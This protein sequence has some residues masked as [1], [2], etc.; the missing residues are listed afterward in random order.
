MLAFVKPT[1]RRCVEDSSE[2]A[3]LLVQLEDSPNF[4]PD[5]H[6]KLAEIGQRLISERRQDERV[7]H[8]VVHDKKCSK[9]DLR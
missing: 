5:F 8:A 9:Y 2:I 6:R 1:C 7:R 3:E 4:H